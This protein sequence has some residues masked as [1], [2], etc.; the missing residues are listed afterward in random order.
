MNVNSILTELQFENFKWF[1][2]DESLILIPLKLFPFLSGSY[3]INDEFRKDFKRKRDSA[4]SNKLLGLRHNQINS[5][6]D[7]RG[8]YIYLPKLLSY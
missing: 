6:H 1:V 5:K 7:R 3:E 4:R 2:F 8:N